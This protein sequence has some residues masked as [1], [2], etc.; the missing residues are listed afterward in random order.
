MRVNVLA[1]DPG[2]L[3]RQAGQYRI[4]QLDDQNEEPVAELCQNHT[5]DQELSFLLEGKK[6]PEKQFQVPFELEM[7]AKTIFILSSD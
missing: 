1:G 2:I 7:G 5:W 3:E 4:Q 6:E